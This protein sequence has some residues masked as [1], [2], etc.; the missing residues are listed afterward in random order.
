VKCA[1]CG[2]EIP[3]GKGIMFVKADGTVLYFCSSKCRKNFNLGRVGRKLKWTKAYREF[4]GV[5]GGKK[6]RSAKA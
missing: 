3:K 4:K 5:K 6:S 1:F 2:N